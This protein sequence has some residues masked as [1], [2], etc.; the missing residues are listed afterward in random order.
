MEED[1][2]GVAEV[3]VKVEA[4]MAAVAVVGKVMVKVAVAGVT[5]TVT[6]LGVA[7]VV[8]WQRVE[9]MMEAICP[10]QSAKAGGSLC[11]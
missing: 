8:E 11:G 9:E 6:A 1:E 7:M 3:A 4:L 2:V 10:E 5:V